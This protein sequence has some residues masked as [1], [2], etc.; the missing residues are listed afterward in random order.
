MDLSFS[1]DF[2]AAEVHGVI[3]GSITFTVIRDDESY[4]YRNFDRIDDDYVQDRIKEVCKILLA[5][6]EF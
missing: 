6:E 4:I 2:D 3:D 1:I 5:I